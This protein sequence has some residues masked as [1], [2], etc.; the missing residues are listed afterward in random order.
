MGAGWRCAE[1]GFGLL[2]F[3]TTWN[4]LATRDDVG[5]RPTGW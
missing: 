4:Y 5:D 2:A 1:P 3:D